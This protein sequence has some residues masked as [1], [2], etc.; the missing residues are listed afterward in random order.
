VVFEDTKLN[1]LPLRMTGAW[2]PQAQGWRWD[3]LALASEPLVGLILCEQSGVLRWARSDHRASQA[4][5]P[6]TLTVTHHGSRIWIFA[7]V[8]RP[9][10]RGLVQAQT[11]VETFD[12]PIFLVD[13]AVT[14]EVVPLWSISG[15]AALTI[16]VLLLSR[17]DARSR[18]LGLWGV[19]P[20]LLGDFGEPW[21]AVL[22]YGRT[23]ELRL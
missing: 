13:E 9:S 10:G 20:S 21:R 22:R 8:G 12:R 7:G 18:R 19:R 3:G 11:A 4:G 23:G 2:F 5:L 1:R 16:S 6:V 15:E 17:R 14:G